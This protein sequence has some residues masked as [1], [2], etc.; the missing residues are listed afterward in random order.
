MISSSTANYA[1]PSHTMY[2]RGEGRLRQALRGMQRI[3]RGGGG[4]PIPAA[5]GS[6]GAPLRSAARGSVGGGRRSLAAHTCSNQSGGGALAAGLDCAG[7]PPPPPPFT[8]DLAAAPFLLPAPF[9]PLESHLLL[10]LLPQAAR[11]DLASRCCS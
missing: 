1:G 7:R 8:P 3:R 4:A 6:G 9:A 10:L 2:G 11:G 5:T